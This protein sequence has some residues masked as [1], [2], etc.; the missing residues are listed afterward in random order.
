[1]SFKIKE[2]MHES[3]INLRYL[4][5]LRHWIESEFIK[6]IIFVEMIARVIK[7]VLRQK[8]RKKMKQLKL[9]LEHECRELIINDCNLIFGNSDISSNY[10]NTTIKQNLIIYFPNALD[11][12]EIEDQSC[13]KKLLHEDD[14][15]LLF[16]KSCDLCNLHFAIKAYEHFSSNPNAYKYTNPLDV[17]DLEE[18]DV[19][20]RHL[21]IVALA[22]GYVL[23]NRARRM[24]GEKNS[25]RLCQI[26][27]EKFKQ[28]L[29]DKPR[30]KHALRELADANNI[31]A[32]QE[33]DPEIK[34]KFIKQAN[35]YYKR[36]VDVDPEDVNTLFKYAVFLEDSLKQINMAEEYFLLALEADSHNHHCM[37]RYADFLDGQ[38]LNDDAEAFYIC[39]SEI[40]HANSKQQR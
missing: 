6:Q 19:C 14:F 16:S 27:I 30:D 4:G 1:M 2:S 24:K 28:A 31:I 15:C 10:W 5:R 38:G 11:N 7:H 40:R 21:N 35:I 22:Q 12:S 23:K 36:A 3:G 13:L 32:K 18:I 20:V 33:N 17:T 8:L 37:Q 9:P 26:A 39:A 29:S 34:K 25:N